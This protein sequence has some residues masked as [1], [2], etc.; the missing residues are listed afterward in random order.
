VV[1]LLF[2]LSRREKINLGA[3]SELY[4]HRCTFISEQHRL[5]LVP[6]REIAQ[7]GGAEKIRR[8]KMGDDRYA[9][10]YIV[11]KAGPRGGHTVMGEVHQRKPAASSK[12]KSDTQPEYKM[13]PN[14]GRK[15]RAAIKA[16]IPQRRR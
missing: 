16:K 2:H 1:D 5:P 11:P 12:V 9:N 13:K 7:R 3:R 6:K 10:V 15:E 14:T 8:I 4:L